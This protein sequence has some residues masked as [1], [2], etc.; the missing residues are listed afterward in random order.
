[1][2]NR[3]ARPLIDNVVRSCVVKT[4]PGKFDV[5]AATLDSLVTIDLDGP[6]RPFWPR[7][8]GSAMISPCRVEVPGEWPCRAVGSNGNDGGNGR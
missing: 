8:E 5:E 6:W 1:M 7:A 2:F 4:A 3:L